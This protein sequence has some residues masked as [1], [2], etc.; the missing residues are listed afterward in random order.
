MATRKSSIGANLVIDRRQ[1]KAAL[2]ASRGDAVK[3]A[4][5]LAAIKAPR[6]G[7]LAGEGMGGWNAG[8]KGM[9]GRYQH[10][11]GA[12]TDVAALAVRAAGAP[13]MYE[14]M[15]D[16]LTA[17]T[18]S[19]EEAKQALDLIAGVSEKQKFEFEP[20]VFAAGKFGSS[21]FEPPRG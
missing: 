8:V 14:D 20:L 18:G 1:F 11:K 4:A 19:A 6:T 7:V 15:N 17:V 5:N 13:S 3:F 2:E 9:I 21:L 16:A 12:V 10:L